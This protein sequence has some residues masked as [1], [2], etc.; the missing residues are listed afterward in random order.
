MATASCAPRTPRT[1]TAAACSPSPAPPAAQN[2][3]G[4]GNYWP[5][6]DTAG[7]WPA[8]G[9]SLCRETETR[10]TP[11]TA[12]IVLHRTRHWSSPGPDL[13][14]LIRTGG[15]QRTSNFLP[16]QS[17]YAELLFRD[18]LWPDTDRTH[19]WQAIDTYTRRDRRFGAARSPLTNPDEHSFAGCSCVI[20]TGHPEFSDRASL[21]TRPAAHSFPLSHFGAAQAVSACSRPAAQLRYFFHPHSAFRA[22]PGQAH[23]GVRAREG[24]A[25]QPVAGAAGWPPAAGVPTRHGPWRRGKSR[26]FR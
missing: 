3:R 8:P 25:G 17:T 1:P 16:W 10:T 15:E 20:R 7:P 2:V 19:L 5:D 13:D 11:F 26:K 22:S 14:L 24:S 21:C 9:W 4:Y 6:A 12:A 18:T 23:T